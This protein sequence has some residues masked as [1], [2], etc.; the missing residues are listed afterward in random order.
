MSEQKY[1]TLEKIIEQLELCGYQTADGLHNLENNAAFLALKSRADDEKW[2]R[3]KTADDLP[4]EEGAYLFRLANKVA[5]GY[6]VHWVAEDGLPKTLSTI[7]SHWQKI[8][9]PREQDQP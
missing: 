6:N 9:S 2:V 4:K 3:I 5:A 8:D 1:E 7:Y